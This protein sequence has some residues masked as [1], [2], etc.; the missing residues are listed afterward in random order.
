MLLV[1]RYTKEVKITLDSTRFATARPFTKFLHSPI[2][3]TS[4]PAAQRAKSST[5]TRLRKSIQKQRKS[6]ESFKSKLSEEKHQ[7]DV[8]EKHKF[9]LSKVHKIINSRWKSEQNAAI[10]IQSAFRGFSSRK[11]YLEVITK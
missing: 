4:L 6:L 10:L 3:D 8:F 5:Q 1:G 9:F 2:R 11:S 7:F